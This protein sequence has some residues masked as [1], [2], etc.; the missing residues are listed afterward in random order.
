MAKESVRLCA[1]SGC[2]R[3]MQCPEAARMTNDRYSDEFDVD[4]CRGSLCGLCPEG[5]KDER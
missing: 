2:V 1:E 3:F 5:E 4:L